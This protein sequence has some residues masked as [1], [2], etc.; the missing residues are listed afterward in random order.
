MLRLNQN[1]DTTI[2]IITKAR[3]MDI[4]DTMAREMP[5]LNPNLD[6]I[7]TIIR[8]RAMDIEDTIMERGRLNQNQA[9][10]IITI[11]RD[12]AMDITMVIMDELVKMFQQLRQSSEF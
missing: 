11:A 8:A 6:I 12:I 9:T 7:I 3:A 2:L 10:I 1:Q 4:E 5:R